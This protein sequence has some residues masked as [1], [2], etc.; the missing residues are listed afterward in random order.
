MTPTRR[1][2]QLAAHTALG[3][4]IFGAP[5]WAALIVNGA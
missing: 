2:A 4:L 3:A 5:V 1:L